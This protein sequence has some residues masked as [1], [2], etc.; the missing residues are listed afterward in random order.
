MASA[1]KDA[2]LGKER[3]RMHRCVAINHSC[4]LQMKTGGSSLSEV[5]NMGK[6]RDLYDAL[7]LSCIVKGAPQRCKSRGALL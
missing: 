4:C 1:A 5:L 2:T 3:D 6:L 7:G